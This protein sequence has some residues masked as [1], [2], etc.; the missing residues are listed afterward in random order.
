MAKPV[1][2]RAPLIVVLAVAVALPLLVA[3]PSA[4]GQAGEWRSY[5]ADKAGT[6]YSPLDQIDAETVHDLRVV[7]RQS[8]IPDETR[9]GNTLRA[10]GASQNTPLMA[11]GLLFISTGLG[12]VAALDATTG[13]V[14]WEMELPGGTTAAPMSYRV[15]GKQYIV[16]AVGWDDMPSEYV[17][18]ALP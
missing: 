10:P 2:P 17:A 3:V 7:W 4:A 13:N 8:T 6:K 5:A 14:V 18:L 11:G 12:M 1:V 9:Q 15:D 16:V